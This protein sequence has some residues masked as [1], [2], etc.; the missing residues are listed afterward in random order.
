VELR[1]VLAEMPNSDGPDGH[2]AWFA[3]HPRKDV[4]GE[5]ITTLAQQVRSLQDEMIMLKQAVDRIDRQHEFLPRRDKL[6]SERAIAVVS[7]RG[8]YHPPIITALDDGELLLAYRDGLDHIGD[9]GI[10]VLLRSRDG[11]RTWGERSVI[12][13]DDATDH[14]IEAIT[15]LRDGSLL[16]VDS[17]D[18]SYDEHHNYS[19]RVP[20]ATASYRGRKGPLW[21][22]RSTDRGRTW[23]IHSGPHF[24][25]IRSLEVTKPILELPSGRLLMPMYYLPEHLHGKQADPADWSFVITIQSS[26]DGGKTWRELY[27]ISRQNP[28]L[29]GEHMLCRTKSGRLMIMVRTEP[30]AWYG[31]GLEGAAVQIISEDEGKTWS[32][33]EATP[34]PSLASPLHL[35][36]LRDGRL[37]CTFGT[38]KDP[39]YV[40]VCVSHDEGRTWDWANRKVITE[41]LRPY[42]CGYPSTAELPD[43]TLVT[44]YYNSLRS[45]WYVAAHRYRL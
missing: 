32:R 43:G 1:V 25:G 23:S 16:C 6:V 33:P 9:N 39:A 4:L 30:G 34:I 38:R 40:G 28:P 42:D 3:L 45:R 11:G 17:L 20:T 12:A 26:D 41:D 31:P 14:R 27:A 24:K 18:C 35:L 5:T 15:P 36:T 37:L 8:H 13:Q 21:V 10:G 7:D 44:V 29:T 22:L 2:I 19:W